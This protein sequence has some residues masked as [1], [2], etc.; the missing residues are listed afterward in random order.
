LRAEGWREKK[1]WMKANVRENDSIPA[2]VQMVYVCYV[3]RGFKKGLGREER[4]K[5]GSEGLEL[6]SNDV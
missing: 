6:T 2:L 3:F 4:L 5:D 1:I